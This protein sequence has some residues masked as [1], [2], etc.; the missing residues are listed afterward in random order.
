MKN[1]P[2]TSRQRALIKKWTLAGKLEQQEIAARLDLTRAGV[3]MVQREL[4]VRQ[5]V[6]DREPLSQKTQNK[7]SAMLKKNL[8]RIRISRETG[9]T[10]G[11]IDGI[12]RRIHFRRR[13][14]SVGVGYR[15][16]K[17]EIARIREALSE[18][19]RTLCKRFHVSRWWLRKFRLG[20]FSRKPK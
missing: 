12:A 3:W 18:S 17:P 9:V 10:L 11:K 5:R 1:Q 13:R 14:G 15:L 2:V 16:R 19:E 7:I 20:S 4:R 8:G 6:S